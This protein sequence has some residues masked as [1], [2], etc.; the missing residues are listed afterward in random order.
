VIGLF[1]DDEKSDTVISVDLIERIDIR[2]DVFEDEHN[3]VST[4]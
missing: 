3:V 1:A 4:I 2:S